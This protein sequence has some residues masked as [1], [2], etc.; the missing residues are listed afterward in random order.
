[1]TKLQ[2]IDWSLP[3]SSRRQPVFGDAAVATSQ[4]LAAQAG[5]EMLRRGGTAIDAAVA[6]A[7]AMTV[8]EP[9]SNGIG[10]DC[11]ALVWEGDDV[12]GLNASGRAPAALSPERFAGATRMP[13]AGWD[14]VTVPGGVAGWVALWRRYGRLDF[15]EL[16]EPA[17]RYARDG[18]LVAP[19]T[20]AL[21]AR[22]TPNLSRYAEWK[23]VFTIDGRAPAAGE[24][25]RL[26]DHAATLEAIAASEG[27]SFYRGPLAARIAAAAKEDGALL[28]QED[29]AAHEAEWVTPLALDAYGARMHQIPPNG[30]GIVALIAL[31]I[32]ARF[33]LDALTVDCPDLHHLAIEATKLGFSVAH[34]E[35]AD[36]AWMRVAPEELLSP[37]RLDALAARI[38]PTKAQDFDHGPPNRGG[39]ILLCAAD[40]EGR[41]ISLIQSNYMGFGSG[42]VVPGTGIAMHNRGANF[43]VEEGHPNRVAGGKRPYHTIIP[44]FVTTAGGDD[45]AHPEPLVA[46]GVMGGFMQ[47]QGQLQTYLRMVRYGQN[48]QAALDAPR[49]QI[50]SELEVEI[51]PG[52]ED[53]FRAELER[54][55]HRLTP[56][57]TRDVRFGRGQAIRRLAEGYAAASDARG[58]GQAVVL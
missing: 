2:P 36:P 34:R 48:P 35:V 53:S 18:F 37:A 26:P 25:M 46:Y 32:L 43:T 22:A 21:W 41:M 14:P 28:A 30:Q 44:G 39:T 27:E 3:Y 8:L 40:A 17:V 12:V 52:F 31:G 56:A 51:E 5:L 7:M 13:T 1:M 11:F 54:R 29:L 47:P 10:G 15:A 24:R 33:D 19:A 9:T 58:D 20:A 57:A 16:A 45:G 6:T 42:I 4:P 38:D 50:T 55:G 23:R 49:W